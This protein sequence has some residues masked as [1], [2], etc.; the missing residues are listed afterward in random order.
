MRR[1][2]IIAVSKIDPDTYANYA[3]LV[4]KG[5]YPQRPVLAKNSLS[6]WKCAWLVLCGKGDVLL[7]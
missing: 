4:K 7:W 6:R 2:A 5:C 1:P 3:V